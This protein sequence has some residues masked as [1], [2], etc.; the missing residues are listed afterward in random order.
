M[1]TS[2]MR[3]I[4]GGR[5][6][7][8]ASFFPQTAVPIKTQHRSTGT[9]TSTVDTRIS[10]GRPFTRLLSAPGTEI[11]P[12]S[13]RH[14]KHFHIYIAHNPSLLLHT[15]QRLNH[16]GQNRIYCSFS[17]YTTRNCCF[18]SD[19]VSELTCDPAGLYQMQSS[20]VV[21]KTQ[22]LPNTCAI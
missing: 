11:L 5:L 6:F 18:S 4:S 7:L 12:L 2:T 19:V 21:K 17:F 15:T 13:K 9:S 22:M 3:P 16:A 1:K 10:S 14:N 8:D 20:A